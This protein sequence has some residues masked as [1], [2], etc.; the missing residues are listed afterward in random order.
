MASVDG[1]CLTYYMVAIVM[2][3][4]FTIRKIFAKL[5]KCKKFDIENEGQ[6]GEKQDLHQSNENNCF[7]IGDF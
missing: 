5:I 4:L 3:T 1:K 6:G 2:F 7:Y